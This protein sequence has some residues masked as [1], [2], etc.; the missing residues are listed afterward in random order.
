MKLNI[1]VRLKNKTFWMTF[2]PM[3]FVLV[4]QILNLFGIDFDMETWQNIT[5]NIVSVIFM[6][7]GALGIV[8]DPTTEGIEDSDLAMTYEE[9]K[10]K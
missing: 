8:V 10:K 3:I 4:Y 2:I 9:P 1:K 5:L 6:I 7:L